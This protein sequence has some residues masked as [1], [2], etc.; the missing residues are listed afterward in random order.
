LR[1]SLYND[2][3]VVHGR[4]YWPAARACALEHGIIICAEPPPVSVAAL[5]RSPH[6][7][8]LYAGSV[9]VIEHE[10]LCLYE[11]F[12]LNGALPAA[13][14]H[15]A[16]TRLMMAGMDYAA[17]KGVKLT[18]VVDKSR[19]GVGIKA[20]AKRLGFAVKNEQAEVLEGGHD[21][22]AR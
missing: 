2:F 1:L 7:G 9:G 12:V 4:R 17:G 22:R 21:D 5:W 6:G 11:W 3:D 15:A 19:G 10:G 14:R 20:L 18:M 16:A 13:V 8:A